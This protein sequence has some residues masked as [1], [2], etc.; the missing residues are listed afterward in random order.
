MLKAI[1]IRLNAVE[2]LTAFSVA[3]R[4]NEPIERL[5]SVFDVVATVNPATK[6]NHIVNDSARTI[7]RCKRYPMIHIQRVPQSNRTIANRTSMIEVVKRDIP[8]FHLL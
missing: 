4:F 3:K 8:C 1:Q 5:L 7:G 6:R 2:D